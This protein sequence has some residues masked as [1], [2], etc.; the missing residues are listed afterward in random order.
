MYS[1][2]WIIVTLVVC[3]LAH[4]AN[5]ATRSRTIDYQYV[6]GDPYPHQMT[7]TIYP[8][9]FSRLA[10]RPARSDVWV[11]RN[12]EYQVGWYHIPD[13][14]ELSV[15]GDMDTEFVRIARQSKYVEG[16]PVD[17]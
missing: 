10:G 1:L 3:V 7:V 11:N 13:M 4:V 17:G 15:L 14:E 8:G 16:S 5:V 2:T 12:C 9:I 6:A